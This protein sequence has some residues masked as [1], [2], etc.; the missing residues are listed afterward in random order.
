MFC[1][2]ATARL[3]ASP[4][5]KRP[6]LSAG[7]K[8]PAARPAQPAARPAH[9]AGRADRPPPMPPSLAPHRL[10]LCLLAQLTGC[11]SARLALAR[12]SISHSALPAADS[13]CERFIRPEHPANP[14]PN[15]P[16]SPTSAGPRQISRRASSAAPSPY[17]PAAPT[18]ARR[19]CSDRSRG[20]E[21][22]CRAPKEWAGSRGC[23][24]RGLVGSV[25]VG[26]RRG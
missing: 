11:C 5:V 9:P 26:T 13:T 3:A 16:P 8:H 10:D 18:V 12:A 6:P 24:R 17:C 1:F 20:E 14:S 15:S 23:W 21:K 19:T 22:A 4:G 2:Q 25:D 7:A